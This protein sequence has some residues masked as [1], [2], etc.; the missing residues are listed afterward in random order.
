MAAVPYRIYLL[1]S[2]LIPALI[3]SV[4]AGVLVALLNTRVTEEN[5]ISIALFFTAL[6]FTACVRMLKDVWSIWPYAVYA[7]KFRVDDEDKKHIE[8]KPTYIEYLENPLLVISFVSLFVSALVFVFSYFLVPLA[9]SFHPSVL[10][11]VGSF[12]F[13]VILFV[14]ILISADVFFRSYS[15][16]NITPKPIR[17][18]QYINRFYLY[19]EGICFFLLNFSIIHPLN[20]VQELGFDA[21]WVTMLITIS[22]TSFLLLSGAYSNP[23]NYIVGGFNSKLM[24]LT[25]FNEIDQ[26]I[27]ETDIKGAYKVKKFSF[28]FW[29]VSMIFVQMVVVT[30]FMKELDNWFYPFL[31]CAQ[32]IW[33]SCY[34][35]LRKSMLIK[36]AKQALKYHGRTDLQQGYIDIE[37]SKG[38]LT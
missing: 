13:P 1:F 4:I 8:G 26:D 36:S 17:F 34:L 35:Y 6:C 7:N 37:K 31:L 11:L 20:S 38:A 10:W 3:Y 29:W 21:A 14:C 22:I 24:A 18:N 28:L 33:V 5:T 9:F 2:A 19:P 16:E 27:N 25:D 23:I 30:S 12:I 32:V 15:Q